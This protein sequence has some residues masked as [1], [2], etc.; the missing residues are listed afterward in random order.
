MA[1][2]PRVLAHRLVTK[3]G[4]RVVIDAP[5]VMRLRACERRL[6]VQFALGTPS[7]A[8]TVATTQIGQ[9]HAL[10]CDALARALLA[11]PMPRIAGEHWDDA[12]GAAHGARRHRHHRRVALIPS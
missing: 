6:H 11:A 2:T 9:A 5:A 8:W 10:I 3:E 7:V 1:R 12:C 4:G